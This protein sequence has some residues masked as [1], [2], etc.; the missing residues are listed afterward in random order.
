MTNKKKLKI[1]YAEDE[2]ITRMLVSD[3]LGSVADTVSVSNG[4]D[5][6]QH[7]QEDRFDLL[8][9]DLSMPK[10]SGFELI[11]K[12]RESDQSMPIVVTTAFREEYLGLED[13]ATIIE[14]PLDIEKFV[15]LIKT[16]EKLS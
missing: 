11:F 13:H 2:P 8:I 14:K 6:Y 1:L 16:Y 3:I 10:M 7:F 5:A 15:E 4:L 12:I 9:T